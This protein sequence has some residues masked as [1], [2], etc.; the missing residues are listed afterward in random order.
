MKIWKKFKLIDSELIKNEESKNTFETTVKTVRRRNK[1]KK[2]IKINI[3]SFLLFITSFLLYK[4]SL[5]GCKKT[6]YECLT[7]ERIKFFYKLGILTLFSSIIYAILFKYLIKNEY[8]ITL[9]IYSFIF[10][11]QIINNQGENMEHH[12]RFNMI[13]FFFF[14]CIAFIIIKIF[15]NFYKQIRKKKYKKTIIIFS[16]IL[17][18]IITFLIIHRAACNNFY[19]GLGGHQ[20]I[21]N[22]T[23]DAC[24]IGK[25][26]TCDIP[27]LS[28]IALFDY[29]RFITS[30]KDRRNDK[31]T[32]MNFLN[33][34]NPNLTVYN[35]TYYFPN[36][37]IFSF[38]E[39]DWG[40]IN[41]NVFKNISGV[42][43]EGTHDQMWL[44]FDEKD[45][46]HIS[47][48]IPYNETLVKEKRAIAQ[49]NKVKF[50]NVYTIY[51]D[52]L[53]RQHFQRKLKKTSKLLDYLI[54]NRNVKVYNEY[55]IYDIEDN[56]DVFQLFKYHSFTYNTPPNY[57]PMFFGSNPF[58]INQ[59]NSIM[60]HFSNKGYITA[61]AVNS[62]AREAYNIVS[63]F[64]HVKFYPSDYEGSS[65]FCD[66]HFCIPDNKYSVFAGINSKLRRCFYERDTGEY[67]FEYILK[68]LEAYKN[69]R[70]FIR[71]ISNDAHEGTLELIKYIDNAL[72]NFLLEILTKYYDDKTIIIFLSDHGA[73]LVGAYE[74]M[75]SE[76]KNFEKMMGFL[77]FIL[78]K[79]STYKT[80]VQYNEQKFVTPYDIFGTYIDI[81][82][83]ENDRP[84]LDFN[85]QSILEKVNGLERSCNTYDE[86][87]GSSLCRCFDF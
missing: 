27:I 28:K 80:N 12:G 31:K 11:I 84:N 74:L 23:E 71:L 38:R 4:I 83:P 72:H 87:R 19:V 9:L 47:I 32:F 29:S 16:L 73:S 8:F 67:I 42:K 62:C 36:M 70:K 76:D 53:S 50:E 2:I 54:R 7:E 13:G 40:I 59:S 37:N 56:M 43:K 86:L 61:T 55:S 15:E 3:I 81:L 51:I 58:S 20:L 46:G 35:N 48:D 39:S 60:E 79:N 41:V 44:T 25:P 64:Y 45:K 65:I 57:G 49:N 24:Y 68:F 5:R 33:K 26:K 17:I 52:S 14:F 78:P 63:K 1:I 22:K 30:C 85:G 18:I 75:L 77:F 66:P 6:E 34:V 21:N 10:L 69:E 82:Y